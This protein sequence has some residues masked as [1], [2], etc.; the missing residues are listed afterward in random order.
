MKGIVIQGFFHSTTMAKRSKNKMV[1]ICD[2]NG[3]VKRG[4]KL[5]V[6]VA[7]DYFQKLFNSVPVSDAKYDD[8]FED[9]QTKMKI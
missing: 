6:E 5:I 8:V 3:V 9:F 2:E 4:D 1:S 7:T